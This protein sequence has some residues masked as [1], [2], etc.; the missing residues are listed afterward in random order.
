M[1]A[2][3]V[4]LFVLFRTCTGDET[5]DEHVVASVVEPESTTRLVLPHT[6]VEFE[7]D[8]NALLQCRSDPC[9]LSPLLFVLFFIF[10]FPSITQRTKKDTDSSQDLRSALEQKARQG[11]SKR[12]GKKKMKPGQAKTLSDLPA[13]NT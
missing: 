8:I 13:L 7:I 3:V 4:V 12:L 10:S 1:F 5:G 11:G 6:T 2:V 9:F